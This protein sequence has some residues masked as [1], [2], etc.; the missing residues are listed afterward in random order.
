MYM[1]GKPD[2]KVSN[3]DMI[4]HIVTE[5]EKKAAEMRAAREAEEAAQTAAE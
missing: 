3:A 4:E 5:V 2:H 1:A